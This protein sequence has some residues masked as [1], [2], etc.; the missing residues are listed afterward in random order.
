MLGAGVG[1]PGPVK[2]DGTVMGCVNLGWPVFNVS[3]ALEELLNIPIKVANDANI[4]ALGE[5][6]KGG[7]EGYKNIIMVT[8]GTGVGGGVIINGNIIAGDTGAG[9]EIGHINVNPHEKISCNCGRKGCLEQYASATGIVKLAR[10]ILERE[11]CDSKLRNIENITAKD[12]F[13]FAKE[14]CKKK[15]ACIIKCFLHLI[16]PKNSMF[17]FMKIQFQC[18]RC[19]SFAILVYMYTDS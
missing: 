6:Y 5:M 1:V 11:N 4:A 13:D 3:T 8:L 12:V 14:N 10:E 7:G 2:D 15:N 17:Q 9:G 16:L 19:F 18:F